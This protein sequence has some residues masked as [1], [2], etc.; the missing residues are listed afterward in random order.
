[1]RTR[2]LL[3]FR[4]RQ[5]R[6]LWPGLPHDVATLGRCGRGAMPRLLGHAAAVALTLAVLALGGSRSEAQEPPESG[7]VGAERVVVE[8]SIEGEGDPE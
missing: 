1:M 4:A 6:W 8:V 7:D 5:W 2:D 3:E